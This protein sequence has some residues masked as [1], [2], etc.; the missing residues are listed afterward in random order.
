MAGTFPGNPQSTQEQD[1]FPHGKHHSFRNL[2]FV[3]HHQNRCRPPNGKA[4]DRTLTV[5]ASN[6]RAELSRV[7]PETADGGEVGF[8]P[9]RTS[10]LYGKRAEMQFYPCS[11][12]RLYSSLQYGLYPA[13]VSR[14]DYKT[15]TP[16]SRLLVF[17]RSYQRYLFV[18][19]VYLNRRSRLSVCRYTSGSNICTYVQHDSTHPTYIIY[20]GPLT[21]LTF[22]RYNG[23][24]HPPNVQYYFHHIFTKY[25]ISGKLGILEPIWAFWPV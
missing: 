7:P 17:C 11:N 12:V 6:N 25:S 24:Y 18:S 19:C 1:T 9:L 3:S 10:P 15:F 22:T 13:T 14:S 23:P 20:D 4:V 8:G 21:H 5:S 16:F 2:I